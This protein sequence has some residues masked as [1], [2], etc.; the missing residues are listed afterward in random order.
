MSIASPSQRQRTKENPLVL[1]T[2]SS[3]RLRLLKGT[4]G[5]KYELQVN[6]YGGGTYNHWFQINLAQPAWIILRKGGA[7]PKNFQVSAYDLNQTPIQ[8]APIFDA[9]SITDGLNRQGEVYIPY[10]DTVMAAQSDLYNTFLRYRIDLG[11]E[12]YYAL[13]AGSY[14][15]C[16]S[17]TRNEPQDY[18]LGVVIEFPPTEMFIALEDEDVLSYLLQETAIDY[19]KTLNVATPVV[20]NVTISSAPEQ[21]NGFTETSATI[22]TSVTVT[23]LENSTWFI[24]TPIPSEQADQYRVLAEPTSNEYFNS[25]HDH[26]LTEWRESW[27]EEHGPDSNLPELFDPLLNRL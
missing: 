16:I 27:Q 15:V 1:G 17:L 2:F 6:G 7:R 25:I 4:L 10:L 14:L 26:S 11:D 3:T 23:L 5:P 21:P 9:D 8:G 13:N 18:E 12:R 20:S 19:T 24:G 22:N